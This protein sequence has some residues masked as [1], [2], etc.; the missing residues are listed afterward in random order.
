VRRD[1]LT[2]DAGKYL[3]TRKLEDGGWFGL[4]RRFFALA[5]ALP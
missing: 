3:P 2:S 1:D 4:P 5:A